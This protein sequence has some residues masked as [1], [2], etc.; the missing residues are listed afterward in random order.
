MR[1]TKNLR[2]DQDTIS[3]F[4]DVFGGGSLIIGT[5]KAARPGFFVFAHTFIRE[6]IEDVFFKK[7]EL[8]MKA[9]EDSGFPSD[10]GTVATMRAE[11]QK[12]REASELLINAAKE[13]Q[14]GD[15]DARA[16]VGWAASEFLSVFRQHMD[17]LKNLVFPLLEQNLSQEDEH[18]IA[19]GF[20][21]IVFE[22]TMNNDSDKYIKIIETL[23]EE[24]SE[25]K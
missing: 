14:A 4:L 7:E 1:F 16:A 19:E 13:W 12:S 24:L 20:N 17:R 15:E 2:A 8:L 18:R 9:L 10:E 6:Y 25:W 23:E 21:N 22:G 5:S 11:Q 3:R